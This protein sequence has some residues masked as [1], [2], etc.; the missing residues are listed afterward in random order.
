MAFGYFYRGRGQ[1]EDFAI[2]VVYSLTHSVLVSFYVYSN[3]LEEFLLL[4]YDG[5]YWVKDTCLFDELDMATPWFCIV[6]FK[7][8][9]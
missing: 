6:F 1:I 2:C 7:Y 8:L 9:P 3:F 5:Y 4:L